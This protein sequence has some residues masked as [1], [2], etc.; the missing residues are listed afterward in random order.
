MDN[1]FVI[2]RGLFLIVNGIFD[3]LGFL[4]LVM[5]YGKLFFRE[6]VV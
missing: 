3:F 4:V 1:K 2:R 5:I 6:F